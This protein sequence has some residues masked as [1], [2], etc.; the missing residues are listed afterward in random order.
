MSSLLE[1][2]GEEMTKTTRSP[3][4]KYEKTR[5][6][7]DRTPLHRHNEGVADTPENISKWNASLG[8]AGMVR[9]NASVRAADRR[10]FTGR[11][12]R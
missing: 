11:K 7:Y 1:W 6:S 12:Q 8:I 10:K 9:F 3:Y 4:R 2:R 5:V